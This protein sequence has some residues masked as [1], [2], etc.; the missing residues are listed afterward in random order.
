MKK[1]IITIS[2]IICVI[3]ILPGL[4]LLSLYIVSPKPKAPPKIINNI[5]DIDNY[6]K[7]L[8]GNQTPPAISITILKKGETVYAKA[9]GYADF[10]QKKIAQLDTIYPWWSVTKIFTA[11]AIM[12]L[13]EKKKL[14]LDDPLEKFIPEFKVKNKD[15]ISK[16]IT[17][18]QLLTHRSGLKDLMPEGLTWIRLADKPKP[19]QTEFFKEKIKGKYQILKFEPGS[20]TSYTSIGYLALG[21]VIETITG[22]E[23]EEYVYENILKPLNMKTTSFVRNKELQSK[24]ATG[25]NPVINLFTGLLWL[26]GEKGSNKTYARETLNGRIWFQ[27]LY[28]NY[29]PS[30]GLSGTSEEMAR[31][32]LLFLQKGILNKQRILTKDSINKMLISYNPDELGNSYNDELY[33]LGWKTWKINNQIVYGHGGGGPGFG[34]LLVIIPE[35]EL[36]IAINANDTNLNRSAL[37]VMLAS[38][39]W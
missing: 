6:L 28:T 29:T 23:Y 7:K 13:Y 3:I 22:I 18:R 38:F 4:I 16:T 1:I 9:F 12:Q 35:R 15:G 19:N 37:A 14:D 30:T 34:A 27:P 10:P 24:T 17:I 11:T 25:S 2:I 5:S 33:G 31:I 39:K 26:Y 20:K 32:G 21:V 36:V 8:T